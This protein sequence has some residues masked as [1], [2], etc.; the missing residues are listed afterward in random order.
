V[1]AASLI[2]SVRQAIC[3]PRKLPA[4]RRR[5]PAQRKGRAVRPMPTPVTWHYLHS[6]NTSLAFAK[7]VDS[8]A[9]DCALGLAA[10]GLRSGLS[11]GGTVDASRCV[12]PGANLGAGMFEARPLLAR[13]LLA[14]AEN[15]HLV[16]SGICFRHS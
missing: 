9:V 3:T 11:V 13:G 16:W 8:A 10:L 15:A 6:K 2:H 7:L 12:Q 5:S 14:L 1:S 4:S